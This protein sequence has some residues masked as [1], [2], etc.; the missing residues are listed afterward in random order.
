MKT[1]IPAIAAVVAAT[2]IASAQN[3]D[4]RRLPGNFIPSQS[5]SQSVQIQGGRVQVS[6]D[7]GVDDV[8]TLGSAGSYRPGPGVQEGPQVVVPSYV[9]PVPKTVEQTGP[10]SSEGKARVVNGG[11]VLVGGRTFAL[12]GLVGPSSDETC[13]D[14][15]GLAWKCGEEAGRRLERFIDGRRV[16]CIGVATEET[17]TVVTG[18]C[19]VGREDIAR[20]QVLDGFART[21]GR[22][23]IEQ[24]AA[25]QNGRGIW[26]IGT[27]SYG[28]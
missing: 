24:H 27:R 3:V 20:I 15:T 17:G 6:P 23:A 22:Y 19:F 16:K 8:V 28:R 9:A 2:S 4:L 5:L 11:L 7:R 10:V 18:T 14:K 1:F 12:E 21:D 26:A 25:V 13:I